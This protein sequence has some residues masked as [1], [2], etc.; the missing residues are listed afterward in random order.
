MQAAC[1]TGRHDR[2]FF[3]G[4]AAHLYVELDGDRLDVDRLRSA[5]ERLYKRHA[6]LRLGISADGD[7][8]LS[9]DDG[10]GQ[11]EVDDFRAL[12][13]AELDRELEAKR[14]QWTHQKLNLRAGQAARFSL[15]LLPEGA[16]RLHVDTDMM[17][18]DPSSFCVLMEDLAR[19]LEDPGA[20]AAPT[21]SFFAWHE[22]LNACPQRRADSARAREWWRARLPSV[23]PAPTLPSRDEGAGP[24]RSLRL[25]HWLAPEQRAALRRLAAE[26]RVTPTV[27]MLGLFALSL[28][29]AT[30]DRRFRLNVP[31][32]WR[33]PLVDGVEDIAGEFAN[34]TLV[35]VELD[36]ADSPAMLCGQLAEQLAALLSH[37][38]YSGVNVMRDLSRH[39][40][41]PCI[42]PVVFTSAMDPPG[43]E[44]LSDRVRQQLGTMT[45]TISQGPQVALDA[46]VAAHDGGLLINWDIRLDAL[47]ERWVRQAFDGFVGLV[48]AVADGQMALDQPVADP[49]GGEKETRPL[50]ALQQAYLLGRSNSQ[51]LGGV[52]MQEFREY[53]GRCEPALLRER[54]AHMVDQ[55]A[56]LRTHIDERELRQWVSDERRINLHE[57][58]LSD[59]SRAEA[60]RVI[61]QRRGL[62]CQELFDL[63]HSPWDV[64]LFHLPEDG[65]AENLVVF[66][67]FDALIVDGWSIAALA[68]Q[69]FEGHEPEP[70]AGTAD[71]PAGAVASNR[72][73]D[74]EYWTAK[75]EAVAAPPCL[76]W[77]RPL[78]Q[79]R[80]GRFERQSR[81][82][83]KALFEAMSRHCARQGLFKNSA[84]MALVLQVLS[85]WLDEGDLCVGIPV[86][87]GAGAE[88]GNRSSFI[89]VNWRPG[90]GDFPDRAMALQRDI[91]EGLD[92]LAFSGVDLGRLLY[93]RTGV[94]PTLPVVVTNGLS[95]PVAGGDGAL[96]FQGGLTQ[97]PQVAMDVRFSRNGDGGLV[98]DI[99]YVRDA[100][101]PAMV[102]DILDALERAVRVVSTSGALALEA[103]SIIDTRHYSL[104]DPG[105]AEPGQ[106]AFLA[107]IAE[108]L[109]DDRN[110]ATAIIS[111][112]QRITYS[113]LGRTVKRIMGG[114]TAKGLAAG[115]V[116]AICLP[117]CPEHTAVTLACALLGLV[118]VPVDASSPPD[119]LDYLLGACRPRLVVASRPP[120]GGHK[121]VAPS[122]LMAA[123]PLA[124]HPDPVALS[125]SPA[126]AFYLYTSGTTGKPKCVVLNNRAAGNVIGR[127]LEHWRITGDD[128]FLSVTPLHH[129]MSVFDVF[130]SLTAGAT[131]VLPEPGEEKN[132]I[133]WNRLIEE[134]GVTLWCS[135]PSILEMLLD[136]SQGNGLRGLRLIAQGGDYIKPAVI[137]ELRRRLPEARLFSLGG[138]TETTIWSLW[139]E[140][141][142]DDTE[143]IP[144]GTPLPGNA[145]FLLDEQGNHCPA[146]VAGR[147]HT[148]GVNL[149]LGYLE[150]GAVNEK[151]FVTIQDHHGN[152]VRAFRTGDRGR[153]RRDGVMLFESRV[154]GYIKVH[155]VRVSLPDIDNVMVGHDAVRHALAVDYGEP[156]RGETG[157]CLVYVPM[158]GAEPATAALRD[159]ARR[160]LPQTHVP[161][162]FLAV[163]SLPLTANG[164]PD[165]RR[166]RQL[167][168]E[169]TER[170]PAPP[171]VDRHQQSPRLDQLLA[172]YREVLSSPN[173]D[174]L[175][176]R[177]DLVEAGLRPRHLGMVAARLGQIFSMEL[178]A[179]RL[180]RCRT[181][182]DVARML[183]VAG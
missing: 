171:P 85:H 13:P 96:R 101:E 92:H 2:A 123:E 164:K 125:A 36:R 87:P 42:A 41:G 6:M 98:F 46:Q 149:A 44:L 167:S 180:A 75:L 162:R 5:L 84:I 104:S 15:S 102:A 59:R 26:H 119:R 143:V 146:G 78:E 53:R 134:H 90:Q 3:G 57:I 114:L 115:D 63:R 29:R 68:R 93:E 175:S 150:E 18:V 62:Y 109:F 83:P 89:A 121:S 145:H 113:E 95:W 24:P 60:L 88:H 131:L 107:T 159:H 97:T 72:A 86:A 69:L 48:R 43:G 31:L 148:T 132:A 73:Q 32:F 161:T 11:L 140:I 27:L 155:G 151:D 181:V 152:S 178:T 112:E 156:R 28:G 19:F 8:Y 108:R 142:A 117:R 17:A 40:G 23:P 56:A 94:A 80:A 139:H 70:A 120:H 67:R 50:N 163:E 111:G 14:H 138:P 71:D 37:A 34:L 166:A 76:P 4:V 169:T 103:G 130:G 38:S 9:D 45:W 136:C 157:I 183:E 128:V 7:P 147:I 124:E 173:P 135:V 91:L 182:E 158:E 105:V 133:R 52:A 58:D 106:D 122:A 35:N 12:D 144:Y 74:R 99:D 22:R 54:L 170:E 110:Q 100:L 160:H 79:I 66:L 116:V 176:A 129:D 16:T 49:G 165:R 174:H 1:W 30:G 77:R 172:V 10:H 179:A 65:E 64:T 39:H 82:V 137:A 154:D 47:P 33:A 168:R 21:A 61:E 177:S 25:A 51:P 81:V 153:Y 20:E 126:P 127:T 141:G 55:H 118:W